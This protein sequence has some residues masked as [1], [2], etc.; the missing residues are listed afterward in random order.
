MNNRER[1][2]GH[3]AQ[4]SDKPLALEILRAE[5]VYLYARDQTYI[6]C[7]SGISVSNLGHG[8]AEVRSAIQQQL[9]RHLHLMVY[10][11]LIQDRQVALAARLAGFLPEKLQSVYFVNSGSEAIEGA[12]KL[13]KRYTGRHRFIAQYHAYHGSTQGALSLM[14]D[15]YFSQSFLPLLPGIDFIE[16]NDIDS[17]ARLI[18]HETAAVFVEP[19][20]GEKGYV[21]CSAEYLQALRSRCDETGT[22][23]VFDEIQSGYG[24]CGELFAFSHYGVIPDVL[25]LAKGFGGGMPLGAF[26][27]SSD[28][29]QVLTDKPVLGHI[30]TFGGHP[31]SC[32]ASLAAL[33]FI[34]RHALAEE[35]KWKETLF[36]TLLQ[37]KAIREVSGMGLMLAVDLVDPQL[38][39]TVIDACVEDGLLI[40]WFLYAEH[41]IRLAPPLIIEEDQIRRI[42]GIILE[43]IDKAMQP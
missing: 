18:T 29:M 40:D 20:M 12:M 2:F 24:R 6:D 1:F 5:G 34:D 15:A 7:I 10:G 16:Q 13:A 32:A 27:A 26:I 38:C 37:H 11:E 33:N 17:V 23:L 8:N 43:N 19:V 25:V 41:K 3:I 28:I 30:T 9:D 31:V 36:R 14:S 21:P 39:R 4:T 22:L 42:C 35:V